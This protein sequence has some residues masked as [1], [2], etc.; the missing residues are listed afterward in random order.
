MNNSTTHCGYIA[1][2][3]R[4]NV[5]KSTLLNHLLGQKVSITSRKPQTTRQ[6]ILGVKTKDDV[7]FIYL[8]TPGLHRD[9]KRNMNYY[10]NRAARIASQEVDVIVFM[11]EANQWNEE[12]QWAFSQIKDVN[13]P[14]ILAVNKIDKMKDRSA[15]LPF[16]KKVSKEFQFH[17]IIPLSAKN[18]DQVE[19]LEKGIAKYL[20]ES[21]FCFPPD[22]VTDRSEQFVASE[23]IR[24][25]LT[26][27][28]GQELPYAITV[29]ILAFE[30][31]EKI[32]RISAVIW[33]EKKG[34]KG[35]VIGKGGGVL[36]KVGMQARIDME[37]FFNQK[38]FLQLWVKV[39]GKEAEYE[40]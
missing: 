8:D 23:I 33:I 37:R 20:P 3:G 2:L 13:C 4:P 36:K 19:T 31:E 21:P 18:G 10:M 11:V 27:V 28:L 25:K 40:D 7:Q 35:I 14:V 39:R 32:T 12:D 5:G 15:L 22:Q 9:E 38:V 26:R 34:Q 17:S 29:S 6:R 24:E 1:I 16:L 30:K